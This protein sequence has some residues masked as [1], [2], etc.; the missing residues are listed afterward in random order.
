MQ[1]LRTGDLV[2]ARRARWRVADIRQHERCQVMRLIAVAPHAGIE[3]R[4]IAPFDLLQ[5]LR[6]TRTPRFV[7][8]SA[9]HSACRSLLSSSEA[10]GSL[11]A[12]GSARVD[13]MPHQLEPAL[14]IIRGL[15][16]RLLLADD[17]GLGKTIQAG[18]V[19]AELVRRGACERLLVLTP[20]G[21]RDQ[22]LRELSDRFKLNVA[23]V[24]A[25]LLRRLASDLPVGTNPWITTPLAITT[26]DYVKRAEVLPAVASCSWDLVIVDEAH[27]V[28]SDSD[29]R[30]AVE[31]LTAAASYVMLLT[32]TPHNGDAALFASLCR[33]GEVD[34]SPL[35]VFRRTRGQVGTA[36]RRRI[37]VVAVHATDSER[38]MHA[39]LERYGNELRRERRRDGRSEP[40]L[41]LSVLHKRAFS[42]A[43]SLAESVER[44]VAALAPA[45]TS[46]ELQDVG[47]Q[48]AL[49]LDDPSGEAIGADQPPLWPDDLAL[50]DRALERRL[51]TPLLFA[52]RLASR[53]E[54][55][56]RRLAV[57]LRRVREPAVV[58]TEYR[59]TL[60][61]LRQHLTRSSI[62][63]HGALTRDQR[64]AALAAFASS[65]S[66]IL[67]ATDAAAEGLNLHRHCRLVINLELPWNPMRLEQ[68][69]GRVDRIGQTRTVHAFHLVA[70]DAGELRI[71]ERLRGRLA[72]AAADIAVPN[73][74]GDEQLA[75]AFLN[76]GRHHGARDAGSSRR[77][78]H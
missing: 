20:A 4:L 45:T 25:P 28:A 40:L 54:S 44:R 58:F 67:L 57:L 64:S 51:L 6:T 71:A 16:T 34:G 27:G 42:S 77:R 18:L 53:A 26:I 66:A 13:V 38:R 62:V 12:A 2:I 56:L 78:T 19:C 50:A 75:R 41:A 23:V 8:T 10:G 72:I 63:L 37:H 43:W 22:W 76:G 68:R 21:L 59:D 48:L 3:R 55:K 60:L 29:R 11:H 9:W 49:P 47:L 31:A 30:T 69:I 70:A 14:A 1:I 73:P 39:L 24:D 17:V 7:R 5:P 65:P 35:V 46:P 74:L 36:T 15:A 52:A 33:L 61:H 32:A